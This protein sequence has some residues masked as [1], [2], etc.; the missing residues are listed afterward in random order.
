MTSP[1]PTPPQR[2]PYLDNV[3]A[4]L[5]TLVVVGHAL[6]PI[7]S[8]TAHAVTVWIYSFHM[9]AFIFVCGMLARTYRGAPRQAARIVTTLLLPYVLFQIIHRVLRT[10]TLD[11][12][13]SVD[14]LTPTWSLWF[15]LAL[16]MWRLLV[17]VFQSLRF[18][19]VTTLA[20]SILAPLIVALDSKLTI[21]RLLSFAP[22]FVAGLVLRPGALDFLRTRLARGM[23][24]AVLAGGLAVVSLAGPLARLSFF[25]FNASYAERDLSAP[26]GM[27]VRC[28]ALIMGAAGTAAI[29]ALT[30]RGRRAWTAIGERTMYV[31][32]LHT[33]PLW[34]VRYHGWG[35][36][37]TTPWHTAAIVAAS[38]A[39][40][41]VLAS[42]P[43]VWL[44]RWLVEPPLAGL[45]VRRDVDRVPVPESRQ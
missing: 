8:T 36:S 4:I 2:D 30:P 35:E 14:L 13:F 7:D 28:A 17:P 23:A 45:L 33:F 22:F 32:L 41:V 24:W 3:R 1:E 37:W 25:L 39:I 38:I 19:L 5:I 27:A 43:M 12:E 6:E 40:T 26:V 16:A 31:Y 29:L 10:V 11:A 9:P 18:P 21:A 20:I 42:R 44:T 15:L 34:G